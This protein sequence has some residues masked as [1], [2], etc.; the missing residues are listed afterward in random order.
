MR[1]C[2]VTPYRYQQ[3]RGRNGLILPRP[4]YPQKQKIKLIINQGNS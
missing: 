2:G 3:G 4:G 1:A